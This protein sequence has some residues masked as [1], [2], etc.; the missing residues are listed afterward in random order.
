MDVSLHRA[1]KTWQLIWFFGSAPLVFVW[2]NK[3]MPLSVPTY[4]PRQIADAA[5][6]FNAWKPCPFPRNA[7][8]GWTEASLVTWALTRQVRPD[9]S[10]GFVLAMARKQYG[11]WI[12]GNDYYQYMP[13][14]TKQ[15]ANG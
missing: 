15:S 6:A 2:E 7:L 9:L 8:L 3:A 10:D 11:E 1:A 12:G 5:N 14:P 13:L 4:T